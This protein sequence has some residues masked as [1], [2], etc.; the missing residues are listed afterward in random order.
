MA[1][2]AR[3]RIAHLGGYQAYVANLIALLGQ[4]ASSQKRRLIE[5]GGL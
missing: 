4:P 2:L 5:L 1:P 3:E